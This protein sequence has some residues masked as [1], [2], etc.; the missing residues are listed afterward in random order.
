MP[1]T[2][3]LSTSAARV[4]TG[5]GLAAYGLA[6]AW[7]LLTGHTRIS[8]SL[9][10]SAPGLPLWGAILPPLAA[11]VLARL[12]PPRRDV[13]VPLTGLPPD[14]LRK[15]AWTLAGLAL[16]VAAVVPFA[17]GLLYPLVKVL[18]LLVVPLVVLRVTRGDGPRAAAIPAPVTWVAP[19]PAVA[20]WFLLS[21]VGPFA[22]PLPEQLPDPVTLV[23]GSLITLLTASVLEEIF[24]RCWLQTRLEA[25]YGR[26]PAIMV[27]S[28]LFALMHTTRIS[29]D[30]VVLGFATIVAFQGVFGL[31]VG[32]LWSRYRNVWVILF[33]HITVNLVFVPML[34]A[35]L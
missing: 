10:P 2:P 4:L 21:Q 31:M 33:I 14:R 1:S 12:V 11:I 29:P 13:P 16:L 34:I 27:S 3:V 6:Y 26:W 8:P 25:L 19:L 28:L 20:A 32:Y 17:E 23:V 30:A 35:R 22:M 5:A 24:Y 18:L 9:D 7:L 15:E